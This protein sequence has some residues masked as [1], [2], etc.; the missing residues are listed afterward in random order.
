MDYLADFL[1]I[2]EESSEVVPVG[3]PDFWIIEYLSFQAFPKSSRLNKA[4][5]SVEAV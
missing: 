4:S 3:P 2:G 5:F 1:G